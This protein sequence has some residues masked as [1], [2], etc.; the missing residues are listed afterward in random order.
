MWRI[1]PPKENTA[2]KIRMRQF[3]F[4]EN[5]DISVYV[6]N[7]MNFLLFVALYYHLLLV[8]STAFLIFYCLSIYI[9]T[10][11]KPQKFQVQQ[12]IYSFKLSSITGN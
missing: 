3:F 9:Y 12:S 7:K 2:P 1:F 8:K 6:A 5:S 10:L 11:S 4:F